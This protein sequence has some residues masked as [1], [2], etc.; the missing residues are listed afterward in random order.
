MM[1][2]PIF[3]A[4]DYAIGGKLIQGKVVLDASYEEL[5][6]TDHEARMRVKTALVQQLAEYMLE[7]KLVEF[8]QA[9]EPA[10]YRKIVYVRAYVAPDDQVKILRVANKIT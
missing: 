5:M 6:N 1:N 9:T 4:H 8:T 10:S 2:E 3:T 7:N